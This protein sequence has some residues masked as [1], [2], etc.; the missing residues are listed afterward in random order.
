M[1]FKEEKHSELFR[2]KWL[3]KTYI[4]ACR[5][6]AHVSEVPN[7]LVEV[8]YELIEVPITI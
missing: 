4:F 5:S 8:I 7:V 3:M 6:V 1:K 2:Y